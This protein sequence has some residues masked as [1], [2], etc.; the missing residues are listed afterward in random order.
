VSVDVQVLSATHRNLPALIAENRFREDLFYRLN[1]VSLDLPPLRER[2]EDIPLLAE[3]FVRRLAHKYRWPQLALSP[4]AERHLAGQPWP[5]NVREM[6]NVLARAAILTR[7]R[8]ILP[9]DLRRGAPPEPEA[10]RGRAA[11]GPAWATCCATVA[12]W[13]CWRRPRCS[14]W[15]TLQSCRSWAPTSPSWAAPTCRSRPWSW[16]RRPS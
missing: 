2:R 4:E 11:P 12:C 6:Q 16:W 8:L 5:G 9:E 1:V 3:H 13:C 10:A 14:T 7:G 15:P